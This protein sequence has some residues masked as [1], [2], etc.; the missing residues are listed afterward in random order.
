[1]TFEE[2][3]DEQNDKMAFKMKYP[4]IHSFEK[5]VLD[6]A[7]DQHVNKFVQKMGYR[8]ANFLSLVKFMIGVMVIMNIIACYARPDFLT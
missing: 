1:M 6:G 8:K 4:R 5:K 3:G 7:V 2:I